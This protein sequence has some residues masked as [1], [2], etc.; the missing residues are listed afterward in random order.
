ML[1]NKL[2]IALSDLLTIQSLIGT[3]KKERVITLDTVKTISINGVEGLEFQ[4]G[5][6][7]DNPR[8]FVV[9]KSY[10]GK[11]DFRLYR[12]TFDEPIGDRQDFLDNEM[13]WLFQEPQSEDFVASDLLFSKTLI[14][15]DNE[16]V[17][18]N[19]SLFGETSDKAFVTVHEWI[20]QEEVDYP[21]IILF[22]ESENPNER[23][24][25][26]SLLVGRTIPH[27]DYTLY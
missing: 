6:I 12:D 25:Y 2:T 14:H 9:V 26:I 27:G 22:E 16:Y 4:I 18:K 8:E 3:G 5:S 23:G 15:D 10:K 1:K 21:E 19:P 20:A 13:L 7:V 24:G 11:A 17:E